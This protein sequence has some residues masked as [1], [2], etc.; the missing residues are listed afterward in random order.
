MQYPGHARR[1]DGGMRVERGE[2]RVKHNRVIPALSRDPVCGGGEE[3]HRHCR[4]LDPGSWSGMTL[5]ARQRRCIC[6]GRARDGALRWP[7]ASIRSVI[8]VAADGPCAI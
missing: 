4:L 1:G 2:L 7:R 8:A 6:P 5:E 3:E